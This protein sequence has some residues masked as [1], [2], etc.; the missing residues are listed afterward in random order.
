MVSLFGVVRL[1]IFDLCSRWY[2]YLGWYVYLE[3][4]SIYFLYFFRTIQLLE[5]EDLKRY[6]SYGFVDFISEESVQGALA[7][8]QQ[9]IN[10]QFVRVSKFMPP[11]LMFDLT[12]VS[13]KDAYTMLRKI[14]Q[15]GSNDGKY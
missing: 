8:K 12:S 2:G 1:L 14:E 3:V 5:G 9:L 11:Q 6:K 10:D 7:T 4:Y 13:D 15:V